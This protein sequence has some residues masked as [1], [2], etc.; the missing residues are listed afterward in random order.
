MKAMGVVQMDLAAQI[1]RDRRQPDRT[2]EL[3]Y[4]RLW[5]MVGEA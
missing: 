1:I 2:S 3:A 5:D 4:V